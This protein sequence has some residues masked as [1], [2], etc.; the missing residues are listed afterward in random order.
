M[1]SCVKDKVTTTS[2]FFEPVYKTKTEILQSIKADVP[3]PLATTGKIFMYGNYLFVNEINE[4][5]HIIDNS[6]PAAPVNKHFISIPGNLDLAVKGH[7]LYAD[8]YTELLVIDISDPE[9]PVVKKTFSNV[10]PE[11]AYVNGFVTDSTKYI[12]DWVEHTATTSNEVANGNRMVESG[13]WFA[14]PEMALFSNS[15][16]KA[17]AIVG[18]SG[19]M[20]R[21][22]IARDHLYTVGQANLSA[23]DISNA[24]APVLNNVQNIGWNIET[25]YPLKDKLFIGSQIGMQI[26]SIDNPDAPQWISS[27][28]HACFNDPVV[29]NDTHAFCYTQSY[30]WP[31]HLY[32]WYTAKQ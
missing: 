15:S 3:H 28:A 23:F 18:I 25:I 10:F 5:V 30:S 27:F 32:D 26:F 2:T 9:N 7:I 19:S 8:I 1:Q 31:N 14:V 24:E 21:F 4:G 12:V 6:N 22:T 13:T 17:S 16:T 11:R 20:A 29:A